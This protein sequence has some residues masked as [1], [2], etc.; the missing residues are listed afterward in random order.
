MSDVQSA[1]RNDFDS[2]KIIEPICD[3]SGFNG[4]KIMQQCQNAVKQQLFKRH[5]K[6]KLHL[7]FC[8]VK[9]MKQTKS[10]LFWRPRIFFRYVHLFWI[11]LVLYWSQ[12]FWRALTYY[13]INRMY[14]RVGVVASMLVSQ[15]VFGK[16]SD[17]LICPSKRRRKR[18]RK[19][20]W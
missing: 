10:H 5:T 7:L 14:I 4:K 3:L 18:R 6:K 12:R 16:I 1:C 19:K 13:R 20:K 9:Y 17:S 2:H 11:L 15:P 8:N